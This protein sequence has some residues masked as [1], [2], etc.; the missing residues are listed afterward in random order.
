[1]SNKGHS[2]SCFFWICMGIRSFIYIFIYT[3]YHFERQKLF[4]MDS[5][6]MV[7]DEKNNTN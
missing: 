2:A 5:H 4:I 6:Y 7:N 3:L 1:M